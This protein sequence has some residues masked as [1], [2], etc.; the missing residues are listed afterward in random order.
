MIPT[1]ATDRLILRPHRADDLAPVAATMADPAVMRHI[2]NQTHPREDA[3]RRMLCGPA[4]WMLLGYGYWVVERQVD[5]AFLGQLGFADFKRDMNP[6]IEGLPEL[7][8]VFAAAA[9]GHGYASE[10]VACALHWA[11]AHLAADQIVAIVNPDNAPSIRV[12]EKAG[13]SI[14]EPASYEGEDILLFRRPRPAS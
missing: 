12:A 7:G 1:L 8:Y 11:D 2:G 10:G 5:G 9:H 14:R 4:M 6:G 3:W 13:F